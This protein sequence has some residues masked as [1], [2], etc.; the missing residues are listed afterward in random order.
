MKKKV[1]GPVLLLIMDGWGIRKAR[2]YNAPAIAPTPILDLLVRSCPHSILKASGTDVGLPDGFQGNSE[3]GHLN[4]GA[5]R[6]VYQAIEKINR[7]IKD[8]SFQKNPA[9]RKAM[10][11]AKKKG[12][13]LHLMGLVQSEGV[14]AMTDH[15]AALLRMAKKE[16]VRN[17][18][19]HAFTDGRDSP[20]KSASSHLSQLQS[21][22]D[23]IGIG[24]IKTV[25]GRFYAMDRDTRW[26]R[27]KVAYQCI[28]QGA[29]RQVSSWK[30]ALSTSYAEHDTDEFIK[31]RIIGE[32]Q[33]VKDGDSVIHF[34]Y[35]LD[36]A[37]ELTK[38]FIEPGFQ[39]FQRAK[40][41][42]TY[43]CMTDYYKEARKHGSV[44]FENVDMKGILG[45][46]LAR[47]GK[48]QLRI[49]ETEKFPHVT[50]FF[51]SQKDAPF[52]REDRILIP[53]PREVATYDL[54]PEMSAKK[55][56]DALL[57]TLSKKDHDV[58]ILNFA[59]GDMVGHTGVWE[60]AKEAVRT[61][62]TCIG[63][64]VP[65]ILQRKGAVLIT[66]DHGNC[67]EMAGIHKTSHTLNPV[68]FILVGPD[69]PVKNGRLA[70]VAPTILELIGVR[71]P[72]EMTGSS[73]LG[74]G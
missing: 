6:I 15:C 27:V 62:D 7:A 63:R 57:S 44:A 71:K 50:F 5:G 49:A 74:N 25:I 38:A 68:P 51:N 13:T 60:A 52:R 54:K 34:N 36:R 42:I 55:I 9:L 40:R 33:G 14:H 45:E 8:G 48:S 23:T 21:E 73:L 46:V 32:Y 31:P 29:G 64:I 28:A 12:S 18:F 59:N 37:R 35:R 20:S 17:V 10:V 69:L 30:E 53:S 3:V 4:L 58:I 72:K 66:S 41:H 43:V 39:G 65:E 22:I 1:E 2:P 26:E 16:G 11:Q 61:V 24:E 70:D 56:T 67:E 47:E 19:V